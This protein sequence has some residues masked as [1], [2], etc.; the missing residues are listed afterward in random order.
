M[1]LTE[2]ARLDRL[3]DYTKFHIGI[4][5]TS[6]GALLAAYGSKDTPFFINNLGKHPCIMVLSILCMIVAGIAGGIIASS[7]TVAQNFNELWDGKIGPLGF[8]ILTGRHWA[9]VEHLAFWASAILISFAMI[10]K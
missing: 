10:W 1:S 7:C 2:D 4:Y 8:P 6:A 9:N 5:I 3:F